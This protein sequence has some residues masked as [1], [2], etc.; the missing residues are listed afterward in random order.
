ME[1]HWFG[2]L[3][4]RLPTEPDS[5][6]ERSI[7]GNLEGLLDR[8]ND[9]GLIDAT[10]QQFTS[11]PQQFMSVV[12]AHF[13]TPKPGPGTALFARADAPACGMAKTWKN[14]VATQTAEPYEI[15]CPTSLDDLRTALQK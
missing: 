10:V 13:S 12:S 4:K 7:V 1:L 9:E 5:D 2:N 3:F 15:A 14:Y 8:P 11:D 6:L